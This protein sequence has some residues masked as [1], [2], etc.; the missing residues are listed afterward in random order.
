MERLLIEAGFEV[1]RHDFRHG[2]EHEGVS[3]TVGYGVIARA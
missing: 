2:F 1:I 3:F